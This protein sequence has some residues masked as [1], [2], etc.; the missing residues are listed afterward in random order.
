MVKVKPK[1]VVITGAESTGKSELTVQ[2]ANYFNVPYIPEYA[3][4][5]IENLDRKY[6]LNDVEIIAQKQVEQL[7]LLQKTDYPVIFADT[8]LVITKIWLEVVFNIVPDWMDNELQNASIDLFLVCDIDLPWIPDSVRENGGEKRLELQCK[9]IETIKKY[10]FNFE[11]ISG[12]NETRF[13]NAL[14]SLKHL[15]IK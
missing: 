4:D 10:N 14:K 9:Y 7:N 1:V 13:E 5:Y 2:L 11:I 6:T 12:K 3:R 8:W 15:K